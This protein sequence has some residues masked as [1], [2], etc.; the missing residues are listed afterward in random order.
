MLHFPQMP[1]FEWI[2]LWSHL[3]I[4]GRWHLDCSW[5][6]HS[7]SW[8]G[9]LAFGCDEVREDGV[10]SSATPIVVA[11]VCWWC[12][13]TSVASS[14]ILILGR[15]P[16]S[17]AGE[18][19]SVAG[20]RYHDRR[21][22]LLLRA[23][24]PRDTS[25]CRGP[26]SPPPIPVS[27]G[28]SSLAWTAAHRYRTTLLY[29]LHYYIRALPNSFRLGQVRNVRRRVACVRACVRTFVRS[30][31]RSTANP[32][33]KTSSQ[34]AEGEKAARSSAGKAHGRQQKTRKPL[35]ILRSW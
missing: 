5:S 31:V 6:L 32:C 4:R 14:H 24:Y 21:S 25:L 8:L 15:G 23:Y 34:S 19:R 12:V 22:R 27:T 17:W 10:S 33:T 29:L 18:G 20:C 28:I 9:L 7:P 30:F 16:H 1:F 13:S 11:A 35:A 2:L 3:H 26:L